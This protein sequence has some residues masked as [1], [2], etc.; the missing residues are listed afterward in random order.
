MLYATVSTGYKAGG[1]FDGVGDVYYESEEIIFY[2]IGW[3]NR[4]LDNRLQ[5]NI[6]AFH[7]EYKNFQVSS[8][9]LT[10]SSGQLGTFT[11][12][13]PT[14]PLD[15]VEIEN[16][17]QISQDDKLYLNIS[18][19]QSEFKNFVVNATDINDTFIQ[20]DLS[21]NELTKTPNWTV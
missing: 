12:N 2:E 13:I 3:K 19:L 6:T 14:M 9:E 17:Y 4:F 8:V 16:S 20:R 1:F 11:R 5:V 21:N 10:P 7:Y 18:Y 15:G